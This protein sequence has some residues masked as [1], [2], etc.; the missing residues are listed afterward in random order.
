MLRGLHRAMHFAAQGAAEHRSI[1][2]LQL[3][4]LLLR[5]TE[6]RPGAQPRARSTG[7][8]RSCAGICCSAGCGA[9]LAGWRPPA[10]VSTFA[11]V[12]GMLSL[13]E[14][15][16]PRR[17]PWLSIGT[18]HL[19]CHPLPST[20]G[21]AAP[22]CAGWDER[23]AI[24]ERMGDAFSLGEGNQPQHAMAARPWLGFASELSGLDR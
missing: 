12:P 20:C 17:G 5:C 10:V 14:Q 19:T 7:Q 1:T 21:P 24:R 16:V 15:G 22:P 3:F 4:S 2:C 23:R 18:Q 13:R 8:A 11:S 9:L 6:G